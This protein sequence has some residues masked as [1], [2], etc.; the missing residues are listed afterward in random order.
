[1]NI[2]RPLWSFVIL[3]SVSNSCLRLVYIFLLDTEN[4]SDL[5]HE[6]SLLPVL[7]SARL[8]ENVILGCSPPGLLFCR[9]ENIS[10]ENIS[11]GHPTPTVRWSKDGRLLDLSS[12][13]RI[14]I[15]GRSFQ[16]HFTTQQ[17]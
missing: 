4:I 8:G 10:N 17:T 3:S 7:T 11:E 16:P 2:E 15:V 5:Q 6:F 1:M 9:D 12:D 14:Q 13:N